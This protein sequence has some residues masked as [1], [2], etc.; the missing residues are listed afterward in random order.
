MNRYLEIAKA[1]SKNSDM[2]KQVGSVVVR[3]GRVLGI[4]FNREGSCKATPTAWS[5]HAEIQ[6]C[7]NT[8]VRG[9]TVYVWRGH[10]VTGDPRLSRPCQSCYGYLTQAGVKAIVY[11]VNGG[12]EKERI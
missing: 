4:G 5:R 2:G 11:S 1:A 3:G 12:W 8:D 10:R 7:I 9:A 6:A